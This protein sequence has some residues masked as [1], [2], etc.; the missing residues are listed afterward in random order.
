MINGMGFGPSQGPAD[1]VEFNG[2]DTG[3]A[4]LWE[5]TTPALGH[6][7]VR[8]PA[9]ATSGPVIVFNNRVRSNE[10]QFTVI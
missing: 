9:M 8:V 4:S 7:Q 3:R 5:Y 1:R 10:L 6:I 2:V